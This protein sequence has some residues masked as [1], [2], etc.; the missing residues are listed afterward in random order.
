MDPQR[1]RLAALAGPRLLTFEEALQRLRL[2][3][4]L[5]VRLARRA[6]RPGPATARPGGAA[7]P[8]RPARQSRLRSRC[9]PARRLPRSPPAPP[10][11]GPCPPHVP[12]PPR[13]APPA[14]RP[15]PQPHR[16]RDAR[17]RGL[18]GLGVLPRLGVAGA[19]GPV[20]GGKGVQVRPGSLGLESAATP[21]RAVLALPL[22]RGKMAGF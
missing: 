21:R 3:H 15:V 19:P 7:S 2:V 14:G 18:R 20:R 5:H 11:P 10:W 8:A 1:E 16:G 12:R 6:L 17:L 13:S 9:R 22:D 4:H